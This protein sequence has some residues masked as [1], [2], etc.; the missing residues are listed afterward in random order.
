MKIEEIKKWY[1]QH[2]KIFFASIELTQNCNFNCKHCYCANKRDVSLSLNEWRNIIDK[3]HSMGCLFLNFTGGE[4]F[5]FKHFHDVYMYAKNKGFIIDLLTNGSLIT[6]ADIS[7]LK[8]YPPNN[9]AITIYGANESDY[10]N[11]TGDGNNFNKVMKTLYL[12]KENNIQFVLRT[13]ATKTLKSSL[14]S[15]EFEKI[16]EKFNTSFK[17]DPIVFPKTTGNTDPL[18]EC[19]DTSEIVDLEKSNYLRANAWKAIFKKKEAKYCWTCY[20]GVS[21]LAIDFQGNAYV[22]GLY[23]N[24]PISILN[25][26][27]NIVLQHLQKIHCKHKEIVNKNECS[28]C[29][30][31]NV[32]KWCPAYSYIYNQNDYEKI[33]FFC[34]LAEKRAKYFGK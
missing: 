19:L 31:R 8:K 23:R 15:R 18:K 1:I 32:C 25:N 6:N 7:L 13:V 26:D 27:I 12:L 24:H 20:A 2:K 10:L 21:S 34:E 22:C 33:D 30:N 14:L 29:K 17:Y 5:A 4:I 9:I 3:L 11:F 16:A 28:I